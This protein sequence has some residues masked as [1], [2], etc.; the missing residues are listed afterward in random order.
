MTGHQSNG[1]CNVRAH[2]HKVK[3]DYSVS[4]NR[5]VYKQSDCIKAHNQMLLH[6]LHLSRSRYVF[7]L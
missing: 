5:D 6:F 3:C 2:I 1:H 4:R 7:F